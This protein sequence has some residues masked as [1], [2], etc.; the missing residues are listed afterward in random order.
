MDGH[1]KE[2]DCLNCACIADLRAE[3]ERLKKELGEVWHA[4]VERGKKAERE[5]DALLACYREGK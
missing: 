1:A 3:N 2:C 4:Y 5:R